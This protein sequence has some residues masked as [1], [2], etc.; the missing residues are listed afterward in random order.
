M[1]K[2]NSFLK[3]C[4]S[5]STMLSTQTARKTEVEDFAA[6]VAVERGAWMGRSKTGKTD[7]E[8][9]RSDSPAQC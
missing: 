4:P 9:L 6:D 1:I 3:I 7:D 2:P 5:T 8:P